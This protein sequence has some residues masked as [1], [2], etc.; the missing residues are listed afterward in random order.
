MR[1]P[2]LSAGDENNDIIFLDL[3]GK[4]KPAR[5]Q[6][7]GTSGNPN[8]APLLLCDQKPQPQA[9]SKVNPGRV[10]VVWWCFIPQESAI[11]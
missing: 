5:D 4:R 6:K 8:C 9:S 7:S 2:V 11:L 1:T 10:S 3:F